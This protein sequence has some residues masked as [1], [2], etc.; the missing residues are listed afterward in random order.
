MPLNL[1]V[2]YRG[3]QVEFPVLGIFGMLGVG[4]ILFEVI[5]THKIGRIAGPAWV[6]VSI[7]YYCWYRRS[8]NLPVSGSIVHDWEAWSSAKVLEEA[9]EFELLEQYNMA[10]AQRDREHAPRA[11]QKSRV[12]GPPASSG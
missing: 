11:A 5:L 7:L 3:R 10:L 4:L 9:E 6:F 1:P 8:Q 12:P 2:R